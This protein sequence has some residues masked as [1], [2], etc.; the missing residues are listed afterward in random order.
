MNIEERD[1]SMSEIL[2]SVIAVF[3]IIIIAASGTGM[4]VANNESTA[5]GEYLEEVALVISESNYSDAIIQECIAEADQNGYTLT[6]DMAGSSEPGMRR[7]AEVTLEYSYEMKL[8][9]VSDTK[10]KKKII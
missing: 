3:M 10:V 1:L 9:G 7:Y 5:A 8:F 2:K 6:V 4:V